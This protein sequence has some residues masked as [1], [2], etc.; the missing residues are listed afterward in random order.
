LSAARSNTL[1]GGVNA[2]APL[3]TTGNTLGEANKKGK[4]REAVDKAEEEDVQVLP[5]RII[6]AFIATKIHP[7]GLP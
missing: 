2:A 7:T 3:P 5:S 1:S 4:S 6:R